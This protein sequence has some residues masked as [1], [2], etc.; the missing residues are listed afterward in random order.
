MKI[1]GFSTSSQLNLDQAGEIALSRVSLR[2][3]YRKQFLDLG[4]H[5]MERM[6]NLFLASAME[7]HE[8]VI[9]GVI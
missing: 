3:I 4:N 2:M 5:S 9:F 8:Q 6:F 7:K 1:R